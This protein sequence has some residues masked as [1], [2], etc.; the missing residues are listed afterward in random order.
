MRRIA[1]DAR[2][3]RRRIGAGARGRAGFTLI[4]LLVVIAIIALL[5]S[6]LVP[7][8]RLARQRALRVVCMTD[9]R[10]LCQASALYLE[11][12][13]DYWIQNEFPHDVEVVTLNAHS[14][15]LGGFPELAPDSDKSEVPDVFWCPVTPESD[16]RGEIPSSGWALHCGYGYYARLNEVG[17]GSVRPGKEDRI[18]TKEENRGVLWADTV[19][20]FDTWLPPMWWFTHPYAASGNYGAFWDA[21]IDLMEVQHLGMA[22]G[23]IETR[24]GL[25][26][27]LDGANPHNKGS[28]WQTGSFNVGFWYMWWF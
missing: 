16:R 13:D 22:G 19:S 26:E 15:Y 4:E 10:A 12:H 20:Y 24:H 27:I 5:V 28:F 8:L 23:G 11:D 21:P 25:E 18:A 17:G 14:D 3:D 2:V 9:L 1:Q 6:L 7:T